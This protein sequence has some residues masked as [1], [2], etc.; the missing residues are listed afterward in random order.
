MKKIVK[1]DLIDVT[2]N[3]VNVLPKTVVAYIINQFLKI[4]HR[5]LKENEEFSIELRGFGVFTKKKRKPS[6]IKNPKTNES[7]LYQDL[8]SISFRLSKNSL[9]LKEEDLDEKI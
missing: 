2:A 3:E 8:Y 7:H 9:S 4:L 1:A 6:I 5:Q